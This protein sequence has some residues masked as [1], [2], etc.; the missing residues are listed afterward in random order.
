MKSQKILLLTTALILSIN[1]TSCYKNKIENSIKEPIENIN[2][3]FT[4]KKEVS[5]KVLIKS[6]EMIKYLK[7]KINQ[8]LEKPKSEVEFPKVRIITEP[9]AVPFT[10]TILLKAPTT[11]RIEA[12]PES[13]DIISYSWEVVKI[14][15]DLNKD[16]VVLLEHFGKSFSFTFEKKGFIT[17]R[18]TVSNS[19]NEKYSKEIRVIVS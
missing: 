11:L 2:M 14:G 17:I 15:L 5:D 13:G 16:N 9:L 12:I 19:K 10:G 3:L 6:D 18:L 4:N 8:E 1:I 7:E